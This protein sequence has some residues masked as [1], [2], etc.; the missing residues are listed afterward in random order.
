MTEKFRERQRAIFKEFEKEANETGFAVVQI[1]MGNFSRPDLL[2]LMDKTPISFDD[3][4]KLVEEGKFDSGKA[5]ELNNS[6][7]KIRSK[8]D[9]VLSKGRKIEHELQEEK[10]KLVVKI[11]LPCVE[12]GRERYAGKI[13]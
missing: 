6:Y 4:D 8:L 9:R 13:S 12:S 11:G 3:L 1:Q 7:P 2:P 5:E 10:E